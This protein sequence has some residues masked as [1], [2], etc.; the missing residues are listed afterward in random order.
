MTGKPVFQHFNRP[1][2]SVP[3]LTGLAPDEI[4]EAEADWLNDDYDDVGTR[5]AW[6]LVPD[7]VGE[8]DDLEPEK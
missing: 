6:G 2:N 4:A 1:D 7:E 5:T 3:L 8:F